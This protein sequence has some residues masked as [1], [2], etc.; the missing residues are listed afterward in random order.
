[1]TDGWQGR[2]FEDFKAGDVYQHPTGRTVIAADNIWFTG[3]THNPNPIH[4][5]SHYSSQTEFGKPLVKHRIRSRPRGSRLPGAD[6]RNGP[7]AGQK[8]PC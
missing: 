4:F 3:I 5:D 1:M 6:R 7:F 8:R 2:F